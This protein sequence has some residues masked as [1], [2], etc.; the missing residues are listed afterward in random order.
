M[1]LTRTWLERARSALSRHVLVSNIGRVFWKISDNKEAPYFTKL[2]FSLFHPV[3]WD[4]TPAPV[5]ALSQITQQDARAA[6]VDADSLE[7]I[8]LA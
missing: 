5:S 8:L 4:A 3:A 7:T 6:E 2:M 1:L